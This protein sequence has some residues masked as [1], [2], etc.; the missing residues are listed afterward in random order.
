M[1]AS[2]VTGNSPGAEARA[3][4]PGGTAQQA[5][6]REELRA[7]QRFRDLALSVLLNANE[8]W[9]RQKQFAELA[10]LLT[11]RATGKTMRVARD[12]AWDKCSLTSSE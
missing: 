1:S 12:K 10:A 3:N 8:P 11:A 2:G 5:A 7:T 4:A 6:V 9:A